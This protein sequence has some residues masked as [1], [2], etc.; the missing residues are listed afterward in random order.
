M[1]ILLNFI[2]PFIEFL[3]LFVMVNALIGRTK[4]ISK[5]DIIMCI[6]NTV[7]IGL[8]PADSVLLLL[9]TAFILD[10]IY[11][12]LINSKNLTNTFI[13]YTLYFIGLIF[14]QFVVVMVS[15]ILSIDGDSLEEQLLCNIL[16]LL[17]IIL[18]ALFARINTIYNLFVS[19]A[20][21]VRLLL[22]NTYLIL[23]SVMITFKISNSSV[24][25]NIPYFLAVIAFIFAVNI[26]ILYYDNSLNQ[27]KKEVDAYQK[28]IPIYETLI[29]DIRANQH[30][31]SNRLQALYGLASTCKDYDSLVNA[32]KTYTTQSIHQSHCNAL[33]NINMPLLA[34][35]LYSLTDYASKIGININYNIHNFSIF[36]QVP[37]YVLSDLA[38]ILL[39]NAIEATTDANNK[40]IYVELT[41]SDGICTYLVRN[42]VDRAYS[43]E[44]MSAFFKKG[45]TTKNNPKS[46]NS[47]HGYGLY[48]LSKTLSKHNGALGYTCTKYDNKYWIEIQFE[49]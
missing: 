46:N 19:S 27:K 14:I 42:T 18:I 13:A 34:A 38:C 6:I 35:S 41:S 31:Y 1:N 32:L 30:E 8:I 23:F 9:I 11:V 48:A 16:T 49:V 25:M 43:R 26:G 40:A 44:E 5:T 4:I 7:V 33:L 2:S 12:F 37:E 21:P 36:S 47:P 3:F 28:N 39:Q 10:F 17:V 29:A 24:Y 20:M 22:I 45:F 15:S